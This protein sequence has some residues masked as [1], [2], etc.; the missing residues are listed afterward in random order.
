ME[1]LLAMGL[2]PVWSSASPDP[3]QRLQ[4]WVAK[5]ATLY[6]VVE[7]HLLD[8]CQRDGGFWLVVAAVLLVSVDEKA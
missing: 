7:S 6:E 5:A 8:L 3:S 4:P 1:Q 2:R